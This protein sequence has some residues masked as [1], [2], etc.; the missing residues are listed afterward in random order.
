MES[1]VSITNVVCGNNTIIKTPSNLY[2]CMLGDNCFIGPFV[3]IQKG[4]FI[5]DNTRISSHSF[6]CEGVTVGSNCFI[7]HGVMFTNDK[8]KQI[9]RPDCY[10]KTV[11]GNGVKIGSGSVILPVSIG[12]N[13]IVGAG[14]VV[15]KNLESNVTAYGNPAK[16]N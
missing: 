6:L 2:D 10:L 4:V 5:G 8:F 15:T 16:P 1:E 13:C 14:S 9:G 3:E 11:I 12:D 7:G